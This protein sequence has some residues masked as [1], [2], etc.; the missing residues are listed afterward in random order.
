[1]SRARASRIEAALTTSSAAFSPVRGRSALLTGRQG[2]PTEVKLPA[3]SAG[4]NI[5]VPH[6]ISAATTT[7][8]NPAARPASSEMPASATIL[9]RPAGRS[10]CPR[11]AGP[12]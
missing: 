1:M 7:A 4:T 3:R 9:T 2:D 6:G 5:A 12:W 11:R 10:R 8:T